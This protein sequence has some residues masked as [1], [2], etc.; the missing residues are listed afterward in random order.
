MTLTIELTPEQQTQIRE[1]GESAV[2]RMF[3]TPSE[4]SSEAVA[5]IFLLLGLYFI[6]AMGPIPA[7]LEETLNEAS[8]LLAD[9]ILKNGTAEQLAALLPK[10]PASSI[11]EGGDRVY[12]PELAQRIRDGRGKFAHVAASSEAL[13]EDRRES[14]Q[15]ER[16]FQS[17]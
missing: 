3:L 6:G 10:L 12:D 17:H 5:A 4:V 9:D 2:R 15:E 14:A 8:K 16:R 11:E 1:Q 7:E 13:M